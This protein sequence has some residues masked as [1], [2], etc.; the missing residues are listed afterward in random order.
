M[1]T[2]LLIII[3]FGMI[4]IMGFS[5]LPAYGLSCGIP[6]FA[7]SYERHDLLLHGKLVEKKIPDFLSN[8]HSTLIFD[9]I[10]VYKGEFSSS[11][12]IK[13]D[14]SW[15]DFYREGE[16]YVLFADKDGSDYRRDLC[17]PNYL[18]SSSIIKF[19][20]DPSKDSEIYFLY[21]LLSGGEL[22]DIDIRMNTY[23]DLNR[24]EIRNG[25]SNLGSYVFSSENYAMTWFG[26]LQILI[27]LVIVG[28]ISY[29]IYRRTRK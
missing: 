14:L 15:D 18:A 1:K 7:E 5:M 26:A 28:I 17:V 13:A 4:V 8:K 23:S 10:K 29:L 22:E 25:T 2:R 21:N 16:E 24:A 3:A 11:F 6:L 12:T 19:L 27:I 9:T 20:D